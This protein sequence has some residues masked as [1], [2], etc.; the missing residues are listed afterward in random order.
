MSTYLTFKF[1]TLKAWKIEYFTDK[2]KALALLKERASY[3]VS[4]SVLFQR[5]N[6][7]QREILFELIDL[8]IEDKIYF[9]DAVRVISKKKAKKY[10]REYH[11]M[12]MFWKKLLEL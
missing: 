6:K 8:C 2:E 9:D 7:R 1:G 11:E 4:Q 12:E 3:G 10:L 5:D